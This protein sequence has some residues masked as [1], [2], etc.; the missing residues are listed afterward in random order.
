MRSLG[1]LIEMTVIETEKELATAASPGL[2]CSFG[3]DSL[4]LLHL[5]RHLRLPVVTMI[6]PVLN[7][8]EWANGL[9]VAQEWGVAIYGIN[10]E[11]SVLIEKN[12]YIAVQTRYGPL[13]W[14]QSVRPG[15]ACL[16]DAIFVRTPAVNEPL[17]FDML[18][19]G[20]KK[21]DPNFLGETMDDVPAKTTINGQTVLHPLRNWTDKDIWDYIDAYQ[22][23]VDVAR[24]DVKARA[25]IDN[26]KASNDRVHGCVACLDHRNIGQDVLCPKTGTATPCLAA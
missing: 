26:T 13:G 8:A 2:L 18:I 4:V 14:Q 22:I 23:P 24:Y 11:A 1:E 15:T 12:G 5:F 21:G 9:R 3:K 19:A 25:E 20:Q 17:P 7:Q 10:P 16:K 6:P